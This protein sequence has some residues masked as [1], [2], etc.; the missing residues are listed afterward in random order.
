MVVNIAF[1]KGIHFII[2]G[3]GRGVKIKL[4]KV[5]HYGKLMLLI[6]RAKNRLLK[7][8]SLKHRFLIVYGSRF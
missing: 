7:S 8:P 3:R 4:P 6:A 1:F 2:W 5:I